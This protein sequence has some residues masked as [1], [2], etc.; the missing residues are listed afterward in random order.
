[1]ILGCATLA[2]ALGA[3]PQS[4][5]AGTPQRVVASVPSAYRQFGM[6]A[7]LEGDVALVHGGVGARGQATVIVHG[8]DPLSGLW[9][10]RQSVQLP[11]GIVGVTPHAVVRLRGDR[12]VVAQNV[13]PNVRRIVFALRRAPSGLWYV[14]QILPPPAQNPGV[15]FGS[16]LELLEDELLIGDPEL[17]RV[18]RYAWTTSGGWVPSGV[19]QGP[20]SPLGSFGT[21]LAAT[22]EH[23]AVISR[24]DDHVHL[25]ARGPAGDWSL[26]ESI[27]PG[28]VPN[29]GLEGPIALDGDWLVMTGHSGVPA[30]PQI[31]RTLR[32]T[33]VGAGIERWVE[34]PSLNATNLGSTNQLGEVLVLRA[35]T[36]FTLDSFAT[37]TSGGFWRRALV[38]AD[39]DPLR[40][41]W[42]ARSY[43]C[44]IDLGA[45]RMVA[46][47]A[48]DDGT[49]LFGDATVDVSGFSDAGATFYVSIPA[50]ADDCDGDCMPDATQLA[51]QPWLD[52][53]VNGRLDACEPLGLAYCVPLPPHST[54]SAGRL[55]AIGSG[56]P[57]R[58]DLALVGLG[59]PPGEVALTL[60]GEG[61]TTLPVGTLGTLCVAGPRA[62]RLTAQVSLVDALGRIVI[63]VDVTALP[64]PGGSVS[65]QPGEKWSFQVWHRDSGG[66]RSTNALRVTLR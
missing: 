49:L 66:A 64:T 40:E 7:A 60:H 3:A 25:Y 55:V 53:N 2:L 39:F 63:P 57:E 12:A 27:G 51:A 41:Q 54:G 44:A 22:E 50:F 21:S 33:R 24:L 13:A 9:S 47:L 65:V 14:D 52:L 20:L 48:Y 26:Q 19:I 28:P 23:L 32:R 42:I 43:G 4:P 8:R 29:A 10:Q 5:C 17:G 45:E 18:L 59:L 1:M 16:G 35:G 36:L 38:V 15:G 11:S 31:V 34:T 56:R 61:V 58:G 30:S 37:C 46:P 6:A 62:G